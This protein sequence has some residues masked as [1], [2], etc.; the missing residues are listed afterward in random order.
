[1]LRHHLPQG[2]QRQLRSVIDGCV[3][4]EPLHRGHSRQAEKEALDR[5]NAATK[6]YGV[7]ARAM[8]MEIGSQGFEL[9][10][11]LSDPLSRC[12]GQWLMVRGV[13]SVVE[14]GIGSLMGEPIFG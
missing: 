11:L 3:R 14:E 1:M 8:P 2:I 7:G 5:D 6:A 13:G 4:D 12:A 10:S 9:K